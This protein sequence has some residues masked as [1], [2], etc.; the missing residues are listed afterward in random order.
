MRKTID[1]SSSDFCSF[2]QTVKGLFKAITD[3]FV[4]NLYSEKYDKIEE[5]RIL[6]NGYCVPRCIL[7][8]LNGD[9]EYIRT[10]I[11]PHGWPPCPHTCRNK[12]M[13]V[14]LFLV[15]YR[16]LKKS[17]HDEIEWPELTIVCMS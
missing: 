1:F 14:P 9:K 10:A 17:L 7:L 6:Q 2:L 15:A 4:Y 13:S 3:G 12:D 16:E 11:G 8:K 5:N